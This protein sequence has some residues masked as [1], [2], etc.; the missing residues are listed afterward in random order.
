[1]TLH[2]S[3]NKKKPLS[4]VF[5][6]YELTIAV[7][8]RHTRRGHQIPFIINGCEPPCGCCELNSGPL[9]EKS[10]L[11]TTAPSLQPSLASSNKDDLHPFLNKSISL[12]A[13]SHSRSLAR[14]SEVKIEKRDWR[15]HLFVH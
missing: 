14:E 13:A 9:E 11:L 3:C 12:M 5:S 1:M 4:F 8:F 10:V 15:G 6:V 2:C 7:V